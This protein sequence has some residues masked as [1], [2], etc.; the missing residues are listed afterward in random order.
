M[1]QNIHISISEIPWKPQTFNFGDEIFGTDNESIGKFEIIS[2]RSARNEK[3][4]SCTN[5]F[6][7]KVL[8]KLDNTNK[9]Y[10]IFQELVRATKRR[11]ELSDNDRLRFVIRNEE[12]PTAISTKFNKVKDF[13]L[14]D[15]E[16]V[17]RILEYRDIP[18]ENCRIVVQSIKIP[19]GKGKLYLTKDTVSR[20]NCVSTVKN[21]DTICLA[22]SI[23][24]AYANLKPENWSKTQLQDGF[25]KCRKLQREQALKLCRYQFDRLPSPPRHPGAFAPKCVPSPGA[26]AQQKMPGGRANKG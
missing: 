9:V 19:N 18:L 14:I 26:F 11:T 13:A 3:F 7:V 24:T 25:N 6:R 22:R 1:V 17:I 12:L 8:K 15:L 4:K 21:N 23:V 16:N 2:P 5:E 10:Q 20:K